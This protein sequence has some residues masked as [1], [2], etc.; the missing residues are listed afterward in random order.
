MVKIISPAGN[1]LP[2]G[3]SP[4]QQNIIG[5]ENMGLRHFNWLIGLLFVAGCGSV[6]QE[7]GNI[8]NPQ[9]VD[10][11]RIGHSTQREVREL[12]GSP[13][14]VNLYHKERW[15]YLQ[16]RRHKGTRA[17]NRLEIVFDHNGTVQDLR[18]NFQSQLLDPTTLPDEEKPSWWQV[19]MGRGPEIGVPTSSN[20]ANIP[21]RIAARS[22]ERPKTLWE[23]F[24]NN[25]RPQ[26]V[27]PPDIS[28]KTEDSGWWK[29]I[30]SQDPTGASHSQ[31]SEEEASKIADD[32]FY[33][34]DTSATPTPG[35]DKPW[36]RFWSS[37]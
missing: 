7:R 18:R 16:D 1:A 23:K 28:Y 13:T 26:A 15:L 29:G 34:P 17:V 20:N 32:P 2:T 3:L 10:Q 24:F 9:N 8:L 21:K 6:I 4:V 36:W 22:G 14:L 33:R 5:L 19:L 25:E 37:E 35:N 12:L 11:I 27:P 31:L 30:W